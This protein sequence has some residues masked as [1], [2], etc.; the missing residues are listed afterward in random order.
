MN[1]LNER[2]YF[3][4]AVSDCVS[5]IR[6]EDILNEQLLSLLRI[7]LAQSH[8]LLRSFSFQVCE[9]VDDLLVL[10][11]REQ[12]CQL[13]LSFAVVKTVTQKQVVEYFVHQLLLVEHQFAC[14]VSHHY[15]IQIE[16]LVLH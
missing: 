14:Q 8:Q 16:V 7:H 6:L 13:S 15:S 3:V 5:Q 2:L 9:L 1:S 10:V 4:R 11:L 12:V